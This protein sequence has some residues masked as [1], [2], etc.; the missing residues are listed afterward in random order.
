M[1]CLVSGGGSA[2]FEQPVDGVTL[3]DMQETT[4]QLLRAGAPI[5]AL[6]YA[7]ASISPP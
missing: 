3:G 1:I 7:C 6:E 4:R 2:L 5:T